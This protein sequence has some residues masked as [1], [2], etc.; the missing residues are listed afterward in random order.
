MTEAK[1]TTVEKNTDKC[2]VCRGFGFWPIG[3][4]TPIGRMDAGEWGDKCIKCPWC[5]AGTVAEGEKYEA[6][7]EHKK[8]MEMES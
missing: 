8:K 2:E 7:V 5:G 3:H 1:S 4:L 6:L